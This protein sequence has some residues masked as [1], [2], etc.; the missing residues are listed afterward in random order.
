MTYRASAVAQ[1]A[2]RVDHARDIR[3]LFILAASTGLTIVTSALL[4]MMA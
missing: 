1:K 2:A 3:T 4:L